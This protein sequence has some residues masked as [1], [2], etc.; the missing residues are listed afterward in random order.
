MISKFVV[1]ACSKASFHVFYSRD[2]PGS[3]AW[4]TQ[5]ERK[6]DKNQTLNDVKVLRAILGIEKRVG[7][8]RCSL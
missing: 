3:E 1:Q 8:I 5:V 4:L 7:C 6:Q 2:K